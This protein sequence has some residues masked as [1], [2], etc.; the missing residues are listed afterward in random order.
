MLS[1]LKPQENISD[2][3]LKKGLSMLMLDGVC[4]QVMGVLTGGAFLVAFALLLGASNFV[5]GL[6][7]ALGPMTQVLQIPAIYLIEKTGHRKAIVVLTSFLSRSFWFLAAAIPFLV[8]ESYRSI[9]L[10]TVIMSYF[11]LGTFSGL[12]FNSWMRDFIP[13]TIRG[14]YSGKRM[15]IATAVAAFLSLAAGFGID[16]YKRFFP[17]IGIYSVYFTVGGVAGMLGVFFLSKIPEPEMERVRGRNLIKIM[18]EPFR[19]INFRQLMVFLG[20]WNFAINF[21]APF[22]TVYMLKRLDLSMMVI[23]TLSV[24]SQL[25]NI[26]FFRFWGKLADRFSNKSVLA[27]AGPLF[28]LT[29]LI[30]P[31][32]TVPDSYFLTVPLLILIHVL[33]GM[34]TAGVNLCS[35][36]IALKLAPA[37]RSTAYLAA[38]ALVSGIAA[39]VAPVIGGVLAAKL[40]G[41]E[42]SLTFRWISAAFHKTWEMPTVNLKGLDFIFI[43]SFLLGLHSLHRLLAIRE[44]GEVEQGV[45][46][47][48]FRL[49]A[50]KAVKNISNVAG[51]RDLFY[52]PYSRLREILFNNK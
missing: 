26:I 9:A 47:K 5:I 34:S 24:L 10:F 37:G 2:S 4:S 22:F 51:M 13:E 6:I 38:N 18:V 33:T 20:S 29:M 25:V 15:A 12:S 23:V 3:E 19:D 1:F 28:I 44:E 52:F 48:E 31:F 39:T 41:E 16:E 35:G 21:A 17:E 50:R 30:W 36:N 32:T 45:F 43:I 42:L 8:P 14:S 7:A 40:D 11:G 49:E 46:A 27:E